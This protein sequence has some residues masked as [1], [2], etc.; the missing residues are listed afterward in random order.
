V[1]PDCIR[2]RRR[3]PADR[4]PHARELEG[5]PQ[6]RDRFEQGDPTLEPELR[7]TSLGKVNEIGTLYIALAGLMNLVVILDA[8][9]RPAHQLEAARQRKA[10]A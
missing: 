4:S 9:H 6:W 1:R 3:E 10:D 7:G 2:R 8:L 5:D